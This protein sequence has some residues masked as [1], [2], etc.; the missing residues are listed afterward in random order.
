[1]RAGADFDGKDEADAGADYG[2]FGLLGRSAEQSSVSLA[3]MSLLQSMQAQ[4]PMCHSLAMGIS[5]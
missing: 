4:E 5:S 1:M 3:G 2:A